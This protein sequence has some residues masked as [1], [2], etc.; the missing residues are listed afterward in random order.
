MITVGTTPAY[1]SEPQEPPRGALI[2][3]HEV[4][5][6]VPHIK[7]VADRFAAE[8]YLAV[9]PDL[10]GD[11]GVTPDVSG[12]L[13]RAMFSPD[14]RVRTEAQPQLRERMSPTRSPEFAAGALARVRECFDYLTDREDV[15]GRIGIVGFCFGGTQA[16]AL[17]VAEPRL[18][19][20]VPFY[21]HADYDVDR[22]RGIACPVLAF[23]GEKDSRLMDGLAALTDRMAEAAV[24]FRPRVYPDCGHAFFNDSNQFAY[25]EQ[26]ASQAWAET[27]GF[28]AQTMRQEATGTR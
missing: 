8:G 25:N 11:A 21:G 9:A 14:E 17:A 4:W 7:D 27:L 10:L 1:L 23:Y 16:Y 19:A 6:L 3:V 28:L 5:G 2:V 26:A 13:Q 12:E 24:D 22:I 15:G 18:R 20:A